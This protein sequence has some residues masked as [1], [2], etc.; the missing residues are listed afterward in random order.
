MQDVPIND[1]TK[2]LTDHAAALVSRDFGQYLE[3]KGLGHVF[4]SS[5]HPQTNG[6]I[7]RYHRSMKEHVLLHVWQLPQELEAEI[8]RFVEWSAILPAPDEFS[9]HRSLY[10]HQLKR[11]SNMTTTVVAMA[12]DT[13]VAFQSD[14][15][16]SVCEIFLSSRHTGGHA[17]ARIAATNRAKTKLK[18][19]GTRSARLNRET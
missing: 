19:L 6:E 4:A 3:A 15:T 9:F 18:Q 13:P 7:E 17:A 16:G 2:L 10:Y 8:A 14:G 11:T 12:R 1:R 5:F